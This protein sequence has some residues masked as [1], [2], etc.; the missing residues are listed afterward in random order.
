MAE[1][2]TLEPVRSDNRIHEVDEED[3]SEKTRDDQFDTHA[4][5]IRRLRRIGNF[6]R[7]K[8]W[9]VHIK[10]ALILHEQGWAAEW[11]PRFN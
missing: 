7:V 10:N 9:R 2:P 4:C 6:E 11:P 1:R 8:V 5:I 3:H